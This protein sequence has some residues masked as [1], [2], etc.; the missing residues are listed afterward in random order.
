[1]CALKAP[2]F[3]RLTTNLLG[4]PMGID[5][6]CYGKKILWDSQTIAFSKATR[7]AGGWY[8]KPQ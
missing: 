1:M 4:G 5:V 3:F 7:R 2:L 8:S 6:K